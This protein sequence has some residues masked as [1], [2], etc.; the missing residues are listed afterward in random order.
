MLFAVR[1]VQ[2]TAHAVTRHLKPTQAC[3]GVWKSCQRVAF[4]S[5]FP[6]HE[7]L[8]MPALS[9][10]MLAG[11][12]VSWSLNIGDEVIPGNPVAELETDK[13]SIAFEAQDDG[14]IAALLHEEGTQDI[15]V[16][17]PIA[18]VVTDKD[19]VAAFANFTLADATGDSVTTSI[20]P[21]AATEEQPR[22]PAAPPA[23][24]PTT[25][26]PSSSDGARIFASPL[27]RKIA[28]EA[29]I[30]VNGV[31]GTGPN[32]RIVRADVEA[33]IEAGGAVAGAEIAVAAASPEG[34]LAAASFTD[35]N[36]SNIR[37]VIAAKLTESK[38]TVPHYY[39][40]I[41]IDLEQAQE[42]RS[43]FNTTLAD[44]GKKL[45][46]NDFVMKA[47]AMAM[48]HVPEANSS[49]HGDFIR[50]YHDVNINVAISVENGL[51][52]P[53][54]RS[55]NNLGLSDISSSVQDLASKAS[56]NKLGLDD[57]E[58]G[59]FTVSNLGM[60]GV[61]EFAAI[62]TPP[63]AAILAVGTASERVIPDED[64]EIGYRFAEQMTVTLSCD[65]R[66]ID[67]AVGAQWLQ[68]FKGYMEDPQ[69]MLL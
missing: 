10:T 1:N 31:S 67:G 48:K 69:T 36:V 57:L 5:S 51:V 46:I 13:A 62:I 30:T 58:T 41:D 39:L 34:A 42:L 21:T 33:F 3:T 66:V 24:A 60:F 26:V 53:V 44:R 55:V 2:R 16:G 59:T 64:S 68:A 19:D 27:A 23:P 7:I 38:T 63:Q 45:S 20:A 6:D 35:A 17:T 50:E 11:D 14:Y 56:E 43:K 49:W 15:A 47:S 4:F 32:G 25:S 12:L 9:P 37:K 65:H 18:V 52:S 54:V 28:R 8:P 40:T 29:G 61:S 22:A